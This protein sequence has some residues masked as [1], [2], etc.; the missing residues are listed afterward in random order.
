MSSSCP[1]DPFKK[2]RLEK[3]VLPAYFD[4][5][6]IPMILGYKDVRQ[7]AKD[8][9]TFS[10]DTPFRVP[11]PSE[12]NDRSVRQLPIETDPPEHKEYRKIVEPFFNRPRQPEFIAKVEELINELF[13]IAA[14]KDS[15]E[16]VREFSLPLQ[17]R[18]LTYLLGIPESEAK[19]FISWGI[20]VFRK[21]DD[22]KSRGAEL[23]Q[24]LHS[25]IDR[26]EQKP[27]DDFFSQLTL[28]EYQGRNLSRDEMLGF[29]NLVFAGGRDTIIHSVSSVIGI[30]AEKPELLER[31]RDDPKLINTATEEFVRY[32][33]PL[34]HIG[35]T[36]PVST[37]I[38]GEKVEANGRVSLCWASANFDA[39]IFESPEELRIDRRPNPHIG[40]GSG[41]HNCLG[42][43]HARLIIRT[44]LKVMSERAVSIK[45]VDALENLE[46]E[47]NFERKLGYDSLHVKITKI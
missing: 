26:A 32:I 36:C 4:T 6:K 23:E 3:G 20:H 18:A 44:L 5:E 21:T 30:L 25:Q 14:G 17:S 2:A 9:T 42:A 40:F 10:S 1:H 22:G 37:D 24:Y 34:T 43:N 16:I 47:S 45:L 12:E 15:A 38:N 29:S 8:F 13:E 27:E 33:S 41:V 35:R 7:A 46:S 39:D 11:I 19:L 28:A 31:L